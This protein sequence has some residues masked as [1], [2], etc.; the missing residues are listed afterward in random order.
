MATKYYQRKKN[1]EKK[2]VKDT[3][4]FLKNKKTKGKKRPDQ[5]I[6]VLLKEKKKK[7]V[8]VIL[9]GTKVFLRNYSKS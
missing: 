2:H 6:K 4:N 3:K 8:N 7:S 9:N 1:S 5:V